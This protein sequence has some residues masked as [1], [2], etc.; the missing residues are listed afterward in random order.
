[1]LYLLVVVAVLVIGFL[2]GPRPDRDMTVTF[3]PAQLGD[4][5]DGYLAASEAEIGN[6]NPGTEKE[7][8]WRDPATKAQTEFAVI[9]VHGFSATKFETKPVADKVAQ[10]LDAN[11]YYPRLTGHGRDGAGLAEAKLSD[12][13]NDLAETMAI[14]EQIGRKIV[15]IGTSNGASLSTWAL[16]NPDYAKNVVATA[17]ISANYELT[18][19]ATSVANMPWSQTLLPMLSGDQYSWEPF[20]EE[21]GKWWTHS[22]PSQAI[23]PMTSLLANLDDTDLSVIKTPA[24]FIYSPED[25]VVSI[26]KI[27]TV[28]SQWGGKTKLAPL[29]S[30]SNPS[31]HVVAGDIMAPENT[32]PVADMIINWVQETGS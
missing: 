7:I 29:E 30:V 25:T 27:E 9:Y 4:D 11:L 18:G 31:K 32:Q 19:V 12:W 22:Y 28:A 20:N 16:T 10:A 3:D 15:L 21:Q 23:F 14:G 2:L 26:P 6:L 5:L 13:A 1:M 24:L 8:I 17:L